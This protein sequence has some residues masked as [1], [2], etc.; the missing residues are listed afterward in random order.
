MGELE[1]AKLFSCLDVLRDRMGD[2]LTE[3]EAIDAILE[4]NFDAE[5]ALDQLLGKSLAAA[6]PVRVAPKASA[7]GSFPLPG[8]KKSNDL[9]W[10]ALA[11]FRF[12][13]PLVKTVSRF[14]LLHKLK[15]KR[16][17]RSAST[18]PI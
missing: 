9:T 2:T 12:K 10:I 6:Y 5:K 17:T 13:N 18:N 14:P 1:E 3:Q 15:S 8:K 11:L 4:T 7:K 16:A